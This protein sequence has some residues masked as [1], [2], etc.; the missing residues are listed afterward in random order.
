MKR[1]SGSVSLLI[2]LTGNV[3]CVSSGSNVL[4]RPI[5]VGFSRNEI[6]SSSLMEIKST[7]RLEQ[8]T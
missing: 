1:I 2:I 5:M 8:A 6:L 7:S 3:R 4:T